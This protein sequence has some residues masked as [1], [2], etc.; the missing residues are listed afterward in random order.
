MPCFMEKSIV[1]VGIIIML[2]KLSKWNQVENVSYEGT[3]HPHYLS[4]VFTAN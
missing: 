2:M 1:M 4:V 3:P